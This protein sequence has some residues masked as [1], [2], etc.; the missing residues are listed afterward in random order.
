MAI[1]NEKQGDP[2]IAEPAS[3][4]TMNEKQ[5]RAAMLYQHD[6]LCPGDRPYIPM[7]HR[8]YPLPS[9]VTSETVFCTLIIA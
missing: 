2:A 7:L 3:H 5:K 9:P 6:A 4:D 1:G 8:G